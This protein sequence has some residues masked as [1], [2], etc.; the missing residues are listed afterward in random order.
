MSVAV[1]RRALLVGGAAVGV[2]LSIGIGRFV[3]ARE[4][5]TI[6]D[7]LHIAGDGT[8]TLFTSVQDMGQ[9]AWGV[10]AQILADELALDWTAIR[11]A[12]AP[13]EGRYGMY[14]TS[15]LTGGSGSVRQMFE[16][17]RKAGA[18]ARE[19]LV[20]AAA[21]RWNVAP[22]EC[23][24]AGGAVRGPGGSTLAFA[25]L[26][27]DAAALPVPAD[28][29]PLRREQWKLIGRSVP[30]VDIPAKVDGSAVYAADLQLPGLLTATIR[31]CPAFGGRLVAV[32]PAP[33]LRI[34]GVRRVLA[35]KGETV[36]PASDREPLV[37]PDAVVVVADGWWQ[38][39]QGLDALA[40]EWAPP[41][42][43]LLDT[44]ALDGELATLARAGGHIV[45]PR[46]E[47]R[48]DADTARLQDEIAAASLQGFGR[49][50]RVIAA[51]Y[52]VPLLA[53][54]QMEPMSAAARVEKGRAEIWSGTQDATAVVA[55]AAGA[56][57]IAPE[58][59]TAHVLPS[60]GSFGRRYKQDYTA[61]AVL[62]AREVGQP[63]KLIW[64]REE[65]MRQGWYRPAACN[66]LEAALGPEGDILAARIA[67]ASAGTSYA[68][69][70]VSAPGIQSL[71]YPLPGLAISGPTHK[72][73]VPCGPWRSVPHTVNAF[74]VES[75]VDELAVAT[76]RD[77]LALRR[78]L[79]RDNPRALRVLDAAARRS[80]WGTPLP[81]GRGRGLAIWQS[82]GSI[83]AQVV[84]AEVAGATLR[85]G[86]ITCV[87]DCGTAVH[88]DSVRAQGEGSIVMALTAALAGEI[89]L[90]AGAVV[91]GNFDGY[92][93]LTMRQI[94]PIA[95]H[96]LDS[97]DVPPGGV[98]EPMTPPLAGALA[99]AIFAASGRRI[100]SL[101]LSKAG[102]ELA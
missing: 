41:P 55:H 24:V 42:G 84:E 62:I 79:L 5:A 15:Y 10:H 49:A 78:E 56:L 33:A 45:T 20:A 32:D 72:T 22:G 28:P 31:Q 100:R 94:P 88:P 18:A 8:V 101:P 82:F 99:N 1:S 12:Q 27:A 40:P 43:A 77:P 74:A 59:V 66:R 46:D 25:E 63:V 4:A 53:H 37:L 87:I 85:L 89:N 90:A 91:E 76:G 80:G 13:V 3:A 30:R 61:Q 19:M 69:E 81:P 26:A 34:P 9:G 35:F 86:P 67:V 51:E 95:V 21:R 38:A 65:D 11:I 71:L 96:I 7:W 70:L 36:K 98:G 102:L 92:P 48:S 52:R 93:M 17:L 2:G 44:A 6:A 14:G 50:A 68:G 47:K 73:T 64:S 16:P 60:G 54:A 58:Q 23:M 29:K 75:F 97:P 83:V 57:G 39:K